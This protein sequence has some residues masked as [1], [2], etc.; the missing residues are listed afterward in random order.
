MKASDK[1]DTKAVIYKKYRGKCCYC[2][3]QLRYDDATL[4]HWLPRAL[5]GD[6]RRANLRLACESCNSLKDDMHPRQ[7]ELLLLTRNQLR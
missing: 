4:D 6:N 1:R 3:V 7:W 5:G 2:Q